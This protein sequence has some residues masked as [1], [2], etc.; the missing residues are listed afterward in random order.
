M[1]AP[2][3]TNNVPSD[4]AGVTV[5]GVVLSGSHVC[6]RVHRDGAAQVTWRI[7]VGLR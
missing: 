5:P 1:G 2:Y 3:V 4:V 7:Q 6:S